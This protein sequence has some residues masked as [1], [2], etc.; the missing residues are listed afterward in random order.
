MCSVVIYLTDLQFQRNAVPD[1]M[2]LGH[3]FDILYLIIQKSIEAKTHAD[4]SKTTIP[5]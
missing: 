2:V 1:V 5:N 4:V 3:L